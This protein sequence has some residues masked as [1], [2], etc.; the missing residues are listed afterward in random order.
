M[1]IIYVL[2]LDKI[3]VDKVLIDKILMY[4]NVRDLLLKNAHVHLCHILVVSVWNSL[5]I[6]DCF[7][8]CLFELPKNWERG[9]ASPFH[10]GIPGWVG[11]GGT[12]K[13][14]LSPGH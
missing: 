2:F 11:L 10:Q 9:L 8:L 12:L 4:Y 7:N 3:F 6:T 1:F 5:S 14:I 13:V